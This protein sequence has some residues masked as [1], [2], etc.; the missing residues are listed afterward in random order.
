MARVYPKQV[1]VKWNGNSKDGYWM[2]LHET[3]EAAY[4]GAGDDNNVAVF[5]FDHLVRLEKVK[6][7]VIVKDIKK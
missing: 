6:E 1:F 7:P 4:D 5:A 3:A 2:E